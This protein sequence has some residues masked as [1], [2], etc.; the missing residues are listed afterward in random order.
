M[1]I[2]Y[3]EETMFGRFVVENISKTPFGISIVT[4]GD[5][6]KAMPWE[7]VEKTLS[8]Y[9]ST[10]KAQNLVMGYID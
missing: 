5:T 2:V 1:K 3:F 4:T 9:G 7:T 10:P 8:A 6:T